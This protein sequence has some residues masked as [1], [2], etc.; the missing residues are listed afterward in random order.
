MSSKPKVRCEKCGSVL[1]HVLVDEFDR[2]G[3]D[4]FIEYPISPCEVNA[5][6]VDVNPNWTGYYQS[7]EEMVD[8][9]RCPFCKQ[10]P[11]VDTEIQTYDIVR[12]VMFRKK[13][14]RKEDVKLIEWMDR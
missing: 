14:R 13:T 2:N 4:S 5:A 8:T 3:A 7:E 6:F 11:F 1:T 12:V 9:I 10:Y